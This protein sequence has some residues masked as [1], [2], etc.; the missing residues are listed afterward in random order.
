[1]EKELTHHIKHAID[2]R[3]K[4]LDTISCQ[5]KNDQNSLIS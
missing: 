5:S 2:Q 1:M 3:N 4:R